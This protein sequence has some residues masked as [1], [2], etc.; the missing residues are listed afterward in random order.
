MSLTSRHVSAPYTCSLTHK[1][2]SIPRFFLGFQQSH[3]VQF[4][5]L[6]S[7]FPSLAL[8]ILYLIQHFEKSFDLMEGPGDAVGYEE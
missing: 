2:K 6:V 5:I 1:K 7:L 3:V 4:V 8:S